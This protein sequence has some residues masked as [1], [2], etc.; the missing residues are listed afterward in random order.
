LKDGEGMGRN[1]TTISVVGVGVGELVVTVG[2]QH[3]G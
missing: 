2:A 3:G 1:L